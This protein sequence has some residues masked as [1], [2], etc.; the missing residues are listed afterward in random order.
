MEQNMVM[1]AG[2]L[3]LSAV[4]SAIVFVIGRI[5]VEQQKTLRLLLERGDSA[6]DIFNALQPPGALNADT[7]RGILFMALGAAWSGTTVFAGGMGWIFG[8]LPFAAGL[9]FLLFG[10]LNARR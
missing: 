4:V 6:A 3:G 10:K 9:M 2:I 5:K 8:G 7:R 1:A